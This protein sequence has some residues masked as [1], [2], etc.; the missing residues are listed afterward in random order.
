MEQ[1]LYEHVFCIYTETAICWGKIQER[2]N[3]QSDFDDDWL[4]NIQS[5]TQISKF[6]LILDRT[7][8]VI[9][10]RPGGILLYAENRINC[11][12]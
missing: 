3:S 4:S 9:L 11:I 8:P 7:A 12:H 10:F 1:N 5:A 2:R 6:K